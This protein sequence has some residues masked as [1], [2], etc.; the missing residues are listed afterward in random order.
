MYHVIIVLDE[1][2]DESYYHSYVAK[3]GNIECDELPPYADVNKARACYWDADAS[4]WVYD[5][6]KYAELVAEQQAAKAAQEQA[7]QEAEAVPS[8]EELAEAVVELA[9]DISDIEAAI[10]E[11]ARIVGGGEA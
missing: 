4:T 1:V 11:L 3:D 5:E 8:N 10:T 7:K 2:R 6:E 9:G